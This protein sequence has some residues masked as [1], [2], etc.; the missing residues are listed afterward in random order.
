M[1]RTA[2][3][4]GGMALVMAVVIL[5]LITILTTAMLSYTSASSRDSSLKQSSQ[6][7]YALAEAALN[8]GL[9]Q[10]ASNYYDSSGN[11]TNSTTP[12]ATTW[13]TNLGSSQQSPGSSTACTSTSSCMS[14][15]VPSCS[16]YAPAP[17]GCGV[18][19][20]TPSG[21]KQGTVVV[22]GVG[23]APN[24]TGGQPLS[25]TVTEKVDVNQTVQYVTPPPYW[26]EIYAGAPPSGSCDLSLGQGVAITAP[27][28]VGGDLCLTSSA[29][30]SGANVDVKVL[31]W[32]WVRQQG[33]IGSQ[34]G[35]PPRVNTAQIKGGCT[36]GGNTQPTMSSGCTIN[37]TSNGWAIWDNN[38][39]S[40]H[41]PTNPAPDALP[42][43]DWSWISNRQATMGWSCTNGRALTE[44]NFALT[45]NASYSCSSPGLQGSITYTYN[46]SGTSTLAVSGDVY[47]PNNLS[48][49]TTTLVKYTGIAGLFV[50]GTITGANNSYL[51]VKIAAGTCDFANATNS[52]SSGYWDT[53]QSLLLIQ[54]QGAMSATN[55]RFQG[56][57][58]SATSISLTGGQ[59]CTQGP[60]LT[61][62]T[63]TVGQQLNGSFPTF[64]QVPSGTLGSPPPYTLGSP[65]G[66]TF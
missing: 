48:I 56:G 54:S 46:A 38:P 59:G 61:P 41:A 58:Y 43:I 53:T 65:Y 14:W 26:K 50:A 15:S 28:Y 63:L 40:A 64:Q 45:P 11:T 7:S 42:T 9:A 12:F 62:G 34:S 10:L 66:G 25:R 6:S 22:Q 60:L 13:F 33:T 23:R 30:I 16:F 55:L 47:F 35:S 27:L 20:G 39:T 29:S 44:A 17:S 18:I 8:Q 24:P 19:S 51:C 52:G 5:V 4:E 57:I 2:A 31:G 21:S 32:A 1:A 37:S 36:T 3:D 49:S